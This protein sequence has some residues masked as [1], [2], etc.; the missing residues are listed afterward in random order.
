M[1]GPR[2]KLL[3][4]VL[5]LCIL[6][7]STFTL[8]A[9]VD[10][11]GDGTIVENDDEGIV[12]FVNNYNSLIHLFWE[13]SDGKAVK[14][15]VLSR[16]GSVGLNTFP[17]HVF[18]ATFDAEA[19]QR[20]N[21]SQVI[22]EEGVD[23]YAFGPVHG[24]ISPLPVAKETAAPVAV[25]RPIHHSVK[26]LNSRTTAVSAKFR[27]LIP[28]PIKIWYENNQGGS[29]QGSLSLGKEYTLNTYEGHVF[30]FTNEEK[31][32]EF[33]RHVMRKDQ[34]LYLVSDP[35]SPAP[36]ELLAHTAREQEFMAQYLKR[37]GIQWRHYF[38]PNGPRPPP[39]LFMWPASHIG[40]VHTVTSTE[41]YWTCRG[42]KKI[43]QTTPSVNLEL[44][45]VSTAPKA[46]IIENFLSDFEVDE[47][48]SIAQPQIKVSTVGN[49]DGGGARQDS[50]RTSHNAWVG[51]RASVIVE[52]L[53]VRAEHLL[54]IE[55][56]DQKNTEDMQVVHY[57][58]G[59]KYDSH[60]DWGVSGYPESRFITLLLY[61]SDMVDPVA[62]GET[63]FP[64][65]ADGAGFKVH[66][67]K[68]SAV[69]F[70]NL[71]ED[72]NGDDLALHAALPIV[73]GEKWLANFWVWDPQRR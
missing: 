54:R 56:L 42:P 53:F 37:N 26:L 72:G 55:R 16:S 73:R 52:S 29:F 58:H 19:T 51:R 43:C 3:F 71:L 66:P 22:V 44:Q 9:N 18:F 11:Q 41:G 34:V 40:Q 13:G 31:T 15:A 12:N 59:Q 30:F 65:G 28:E 24:H 21:P 36:A 60:H 68:G 33:A 8:G 45:V 35:K 25:A 1:V 69:L 57:E 7:F 70:Y 49:K 64:K 23:Y 67:G 14:M 32:V 47:I 5:T 63:A 10:V 46:F 20:V 39:S 61:L 38:G 48:I 50:T 17:N 6:F 4:G 27:S 2:A 62:G